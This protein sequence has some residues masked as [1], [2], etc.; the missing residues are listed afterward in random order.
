MFIYMQLAMVY[1][2]REV[3]ETL[4]QEKVE[5]G[6]CEQL[7]LIVGALNHLHQDPQGQFL[8]NVEAAPPSCHWTPTSRYYIHQ[9]LLTNCPV[10]PGLLILFTTSVYSCRAYNHTSGEPPQ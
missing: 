8:C 1:I 9:Q 5:L 2:E 6:V 4:D 3:A 10:P 7:R